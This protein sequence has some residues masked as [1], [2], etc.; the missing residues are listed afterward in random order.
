MVLLYFDV[1]TEQNASS[2]VVLFGH[3]H[4]SELLKKQLK[5]MQPDTFKLNRKMSQTDIYQG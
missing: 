2:P 1:K 3:G 4:D 5:N